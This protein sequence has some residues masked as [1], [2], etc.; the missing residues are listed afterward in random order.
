MKF[1]NA[2]SRP[3]VPG[4][5]LTTG[6][7]SLMFT[8][9]LKL[10][11]TRLLLCGGLFLLLM[12][13]LTINVSDSATPVGIYRVKPISKVNYGD[14]VMLRMPIKRALALP[15]DHVR[16]TQQGIYRE[17]KLIPNSAPEPGIPRR[18][19]Y[20]NYTVPPGM[21][22][23]MGTDNPDSWDGRYVG[24]LPLSIVAGKVTPIWP[25]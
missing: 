22:L 19:P 2:I 3:S 23:G 6:K 14:L 20:D 1:S 4:L 21:F 9:V 15:G 11:P 16:F 8:R 12:G 5:A 13:N 17:G 10:I 24:F 25:R 7:T 18:F